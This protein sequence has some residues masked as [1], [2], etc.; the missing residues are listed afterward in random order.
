MVDEPQHILS[1]RIDALEKQ[2]ARVET[3][4][5]NLGSIET[6]IRE[7]SL[8]AQGFRK[9]ID[10]VWKRVDDH[11]AWREEHNADD[12]EEHQK[13]MESVT[14]TNNAIS[15]TVESVEKKVDEWIN[16]ATGAGKVVLWAAGAIQVALIGTLGW[17]FLEITRINHDLVQLQT[18]V[19]EHLRVDQ[20]TIPGC[21]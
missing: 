5:D 12:R 1:P 7:I 9:E 19:A 17:Q 13:I 2:F 10:V 20:C 6:A 16:K 18:Q 8:V 11:H 15:D 3:K 14:K 4:I 21:K